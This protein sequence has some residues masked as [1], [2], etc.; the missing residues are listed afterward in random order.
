MNR[1]SDRLRDLLIEIYCEVN[2]MTMGFTK[3]ELRE[4]L[5]STNEKRL[6]QRRKIIKQKINSALGIL[7]E[8]HVNL[9]FEDIP[10]RLLPE[11]IRKNI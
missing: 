2:N 6:S 8:K 11:D 1:S 9:S 3:S 5:F 4:A 7:L 10:V